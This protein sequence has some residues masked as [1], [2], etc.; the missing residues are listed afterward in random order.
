MEVKPRVGVVGIWHE[1]NTYSNRVT[2]MADFEAFELLDGPPLLEAHQGIGSV[3]GGFCDHQS[4]DLVPIFSAAAW[5]A[6]IVAKTT[7]EDLLARLGSRA[8]GVGP[9]DGLLVNLHG[10]MVAE[11]HEDV[12]F[13]VM[14]LLRQ[15][16]GRIPTAAVVDL[17][18]N[19]SEAMVKLCDVVISYDTYPHDDMRER[20][21]EAADLLGQ[22]LGGRRLVTHIAKAPVLASPLAQATDKEPM[23]GLLARSRQRGIEAGV[24]RVCVVGGFAYSDVSRA[25]MSVLVV[26]DEAHRG[27]ALEVL[28]LTINDIEDS[29][30]GFRIERPG[31]E[32][33]V[34]EALMS[35]VHPVILVDLADNIGGGSP[36]DGTAL[37]AELLRQGP[38]GAVVTIAD[39]EAAGK[40]ADAGI[41]ATID[42]EIGGRADRLHGAPIRVRGTVENVTDGR[43]RTAGTWMQGREFSMGQTALL[44]VNGLAL[45][46][47]EHATPPFHGEQLPAAGV[48]PATASIIVVKGA[49]AWRAGLGT[50][51]AKVI[52]VDTPGICPIDPYSLPRRNSPGLT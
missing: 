32:A 25:G 50:I 10:A 40:A 7:I 1:T 19:L 31:P 49:V 17:H 36:G 2:T 43:Y 46:L 42:L 48:D 21:S 16:F 29:A 44:R 4:F 27:D 5:P 30:L 26:A 33:A 15:S 28:A 6:G 38:T 3:I 20:G 9:L 23:K 13:E 12:E 18:A 14:S 52:E 45:V 35:D 47:T 39:P 41:G 51:A 11:H 37:L 22:M 24:D 8:A 34:A